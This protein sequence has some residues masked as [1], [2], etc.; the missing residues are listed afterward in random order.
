MTKEGSQPSDQDLIIVPVTPEFLVDGVY[1]LHEFQYDLLKGVFVREDR[2]V[3]LEPVERR[4]MNKL[5]RAPFV[6]HDERMLIEGGDTDSLRLLSTH[7]SIIRQAMPVSFDKARKIVQTVKYKGY[8]FFD[9]RIPGHSAAIGRKLKAG[10]EE[11]IPFV[12]HLVPGLKKTEYV[13]EKRAVRKN[14][15]P[16]LTTEKHAHYWLVDEAN[17]EKSDAICKHCGITRQFKNGL[18]DTSREK[19]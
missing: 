10:T 11:R 6:V 18:P 4:I 19:F 14:A 12:Q 1:H 2:V 8:R 16:N 13:P 7:I 15:D 3:E 5:V 17:G 9:D